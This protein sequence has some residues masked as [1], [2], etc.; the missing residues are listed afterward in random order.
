MPQAADVT[1]N[2]KNVFTS[3]DLDEIYKPCGPVS[4]AL[5]SYYVQHVVQSAIDSAFRLAL[6]PADV[7]DEQSA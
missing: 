4:E 5:S 2:G 6:A 3:R 7:T 1:A